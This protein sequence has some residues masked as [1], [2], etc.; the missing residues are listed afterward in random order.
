MSYEWV[1]WLIYG[2]MFMLIF[3][4]VIQMWNLFRDLFEKRK[5]P[6]EKLRTLN[7]RRYKE[8]ISAARLNK[9]KRR[10]KWVYMDTGK[11]FLPKRIGKYAGHIA[12]KRLLILAIKTSRWPWA[13]PIL[14]FVPYSIGNKKI[15]PPLTTRDIH[16]KINSIIR[17]DRW[18]IPEIEHDANIAQEDIISLISDYL[19]T[20]F[21]SVYSTEIL[22]AQSLLS[23]TG[24]ANVN[25][26]IEQ[27]IVYSSAV[28]HAPED[29]EVE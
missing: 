21:D 27:R 18:W 22:P 26:S 23:P 5:S 17:Y 11:Y 14:L 24:A 28:E 20:D 12:D 25:P 19:N 29:K 1:N 3:T 7:Y 15:V 9:P 4:L 2:M 8:L 13:R 16:L 10:I 6:E